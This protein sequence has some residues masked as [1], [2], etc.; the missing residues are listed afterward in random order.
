MSDIRLGLMNAVAEI[1]QLRIKLA[2]AEAERDEL[3]AQLE[4]EREN[5]HDGVLCHSAE[6]LKLTA[7]LAAANARVAEGERE[8]QRYIRELDKRTERAEAAEAREIVL[9]ELLR[10][11]RLVI[12]GEAS[13]DGFYARID[14]A[15]KGYGDE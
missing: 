15:L 14:A 3:R 2:A 4:A 11:A 13:S 12:A 7:E 9:R 10:E 5:F 1:E 6:T 8:F